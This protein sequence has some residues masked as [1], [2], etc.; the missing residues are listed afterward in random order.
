MSSRTR[1]R[2]WF[3]ILL[4][5]AL[6]VA[7]ARGLPP[8]PSP[9][10]E[11]PAAGEETAAGPTPT[12]ITRNVVDG[13]GLIAQLP[14]LEHLPAGWQVT[15]RPRFA[16]R[17]PQPGDTFRFACR[18]L[19]SRTIGSASVGFRRSA[20]PLTLTIEYLVYPTPEDAES[21]LADIRDAAA[22]CPAFD[23]PNVDDP[24]APLPAT[25]TLLPDPALG[26][27]AL[28][29]T[30]LIHVS[31]AAQ[32]ET[33]FYRIREGAYLIGVYQSGEAATAPPDPALTAELARIAGENLRS[34]S[35]GDLK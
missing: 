30:L 27:Q 12:P 19:T 28:A 33:H 35:L 7:C 26:E 22:A 16:A 4:P 15:Q 9:T 18:D 20:S 24:A 29:A 34:L 6:A 21:V 31:D 17:M 14:R 8:D 2:K 32:S 3:I 23:M 10:A 25:L 1:L 11:S 13:A 5:A